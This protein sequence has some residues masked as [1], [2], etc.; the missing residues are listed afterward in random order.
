MLWLTGG[1]LGYIDNNLGEVGYLDILAVWSALFLLRVCAVRT[2]RDVQTWTDVGI[3]HGLH[4]YPITA[5]PPPPTPHPYTPLHTVY[6]RTYVCTYVRTVT[7]TPAQ[8]LHC[9]GSACPQ[10]DSTHLHHTH[11]H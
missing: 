11:T 5:R 2:P 6:V 8:L 3:D 4:P 10:R 1:D 7:G 9:A